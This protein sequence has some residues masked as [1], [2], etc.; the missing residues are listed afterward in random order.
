[1][2]HTCNPSIQEAGSDRTAAEQPGI[3]N[4][5]LAPSRRGQLVSLL[6]KRRDCLREV[7]ELSLLF[8]LQTPTDSII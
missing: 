4:M 5:T 7:T 1:M 8:A 3:P 6:A 2:E